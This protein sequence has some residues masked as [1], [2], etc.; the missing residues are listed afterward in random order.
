MYWLIETFWSSLPKFQ[1]VSILNLVYVFDFDFQISRHEWLKFSNFNFNSLK[2]VDHHFIF[3][4]K[5]T[6]F[7]FRFWFLTCFEPSYNYHENVF[8]SATVETKLMY[9]LIYLNNL[10]DFTK[11]IDNSNLDFHDEIL[12]HARLKL[13][14]LDLVS[15]PNFHIWKSF[16]RIISNLTIST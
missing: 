10:A 1:N 8:K 14:R 12:L 16:F 11:G 9:I 15:K 6:R 4:F 2:F 7:K 13:S 5:P 3:H